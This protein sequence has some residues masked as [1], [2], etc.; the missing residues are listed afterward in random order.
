MEAE[1]GEWLTIPGASAKFAVPERTVYRWARLA[2]QGK[3]SPA[4]ARRVSG[5]R[6]KLEVRITAARVAEGAG[7]QVAEAPPS[8]AELVELRQRVRELG[9]ERERLASETHDLKAQTADLRRLLDQQQQ[10]HASTQRQLERL[11]PAPR[12]DAGE[13]RPWWQRVVGR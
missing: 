5:R 1:K 6:H 9:I 3:P 8:A 13:R 2:L 12:E 4:E 11:L 7:W 10:L